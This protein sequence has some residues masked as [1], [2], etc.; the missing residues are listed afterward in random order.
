MPRSPPFSNE[1]G[2]CS[3]N[4][5]KDTP[6]LITPP[7]Q[8][9]NERIAAFLNRLDEVLTPFVKEG[10]RFELYHLGRSSLV[11]HYGFQLS[12][13]DIDF[14]GRQNRL[15]DDKAIELFGKGTAM[16]ENL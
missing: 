16:A 5:S 9:M 8:A 7:G 15:L 2:G 1:H 10:E 4:G 13:S 3:R 6:S 12:T 11:M 14:V